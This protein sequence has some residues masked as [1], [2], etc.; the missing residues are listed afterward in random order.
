MP[1]CKTLQEALCCILYSGLYGGMGKQEIVRYT[2][3]QEETGGLSVMQKSLK[4]FLC[5]LGAEVERNDKKRFAEY[6]KALDNK[7]GV[8]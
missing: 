1:T 3:T 6:K 2:H 4:A 7:K 8:V 5:S